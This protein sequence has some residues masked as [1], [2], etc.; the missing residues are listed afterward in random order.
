M[1]ISP[2]GGQQS[3]VASSALLGRPVAV[4]VEHAGTILA[5]RPFQ[6]AGGG[7][8]SLPGALIRINPQTHVIAL[9]AE[10]SELTDP[11]A[12]AVANDGTIL[13]AAAA[14][15]FAL[16]RVNGELS[17]LTEAPVQSIAVVPPLPG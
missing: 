7:V 5:I 16:N 1:R 9:V 10:P 14:G 11:R 17:Q 8:T 6:A 12:L 13:V 4:A 2:P 3:K 15:V